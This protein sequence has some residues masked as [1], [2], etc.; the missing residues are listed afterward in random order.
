MLFAVNFTEGDNLLI[1]LDADC[2]EA[3]RSLA[4]KAYEKGA[5]YVG[6]R[7]ND[8]F[9]HAA[10]IKAGKTSIDYPEY[11]KRMLDDTFV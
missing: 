11:L 7:Y 9:L 1:S 8:D 3:V 10:A 6:M 2:R 5:A 4:Y